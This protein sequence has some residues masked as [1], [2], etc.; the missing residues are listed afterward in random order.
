VGAEVRP[1][2]PLDSIESCTPDG[3]N[4]GAV[5]RH[6]SV[7]EH[8]DGE[9]T[10][11]VT[12]YGS[13]DDAAADLERVGGNEWFA[14]HRQQIEDAYGDPNPRFEELPAD[15][16]AP[17]VAYLEHFLSDGRR[18]L[19]TIHYVFVGQVRATITY[20]GCTTVATEGRQEVAR[21]V[22]A[23]LAEVQGLPAPGRDGT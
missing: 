7:Y 14:C 1:A 15:P 23:A 11:N 12:V 4:D 19:D 10:I 20:C 18:S 17:G 13:E 5:N 22:A 21:D 8:S 9:V 2:L 3:W 16:Q 6:S